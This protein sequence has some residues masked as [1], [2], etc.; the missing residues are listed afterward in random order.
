MDVWNRRTYAG[1]VCVR[2]GRIV[3]IEADES[4]RKDRYLLPGWVDA[5]VHIESSLMTPRMFGREAVRHGVV[6]VVTDPH[7]IANVCGVAGIEYMRREGARSAVKCCLTVPSC[8]PSCAYDESGA[9]VT[10][11]DVEGL[12]RTGRFYGLSEVMDAVGVVSGEEELKKK[13]ASARR[14]G[15]VVDGHSP[16]LT[17]AAL[18]KYASAGIVTD[19]ECRTLE[20][21]EERIGLGMKIQIREGSAARNFAA[22]KP[23]IGRY[24]DRVMLCAD[25]ISAD[26]LVGGG[27]IDR[28]VARAVA[29]GYDLYDTV[30]AASVNAV[31][32][33][34]LPVGL[35]REGDRADFQ[36]VSDLK[37]FRVEAVYVD[38]E[39]RDEGW[40][41]PEG[42]ETVLPE[43][44]VHDRIDERELRRGIAHAETIME[45]SDGDV[46]THAYRYDPAEK[47]ENL[48]S[49]PE[50]DIVK[51]VYANRYRNGAPRVS[52]VKGTGI[53]EGAFATSV[54]HDA[55][56]LIAFGSHDR[57]IAAALNAVIEKKGGRA[58]AVHGEVEVLPLPVGGLMSRLGAEE[59]HEECRRMRERFS[60]YPL[61]LSM[62]FMTL[63]FLALL[64]VPEVKI[65]GGGL[66]S[67]AKWGWTGEEES[68]SGERT[69][70]R[71]K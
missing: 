12:L 39:R 48:E 46:V 43:N 45:V 33:Y 61:A 47:S 14:C 63:S 37:D 16:G 41:E 17:G 18:R 10:A 53:R 65:G 26:K 3:S 6:A 38:G 44:F 2:G 1:R 8:V 54:S 57:D 5:H 4:V 22:L 11:E 60:R 62:P 49:D 71:K 28:L 31:E 50:A 68:A 70:G 35:L 58:F 55:H 13:I 9:R 66:F 40:T 21:A 34:R 25:D 19:H 29:D 36:V 56:N 30:R 64:V 59:L 69:E 32:H 20:E 15:L 42:E 52:W 7:E 23:L 27:Y 67:Y 51:I 24:P